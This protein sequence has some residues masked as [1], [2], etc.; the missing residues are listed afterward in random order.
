[1]VTYHEAY[2]TAILD[3]NLADGK[4]WQ[5]SSRPR[6]LVKIG[7]AG[8][9]AKMDCGFDILYGSMKIGHM[10]NTST[11]A[12]DAYTQEHQWWHSSKV[13]IPAGVPVNL[14]MTVA[15]GAAVKL[16]IDFQEM[17]P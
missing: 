9:S 3:Q 8:S 7:F 11:T 12:M 17:T 16:F 2:A 13:F 6:R 5:V 14:I 4:V 15:A 1:M 10:Y